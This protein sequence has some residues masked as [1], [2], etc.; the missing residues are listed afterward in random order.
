MAKLDSTD[1]RI[2]QLLSSNARASIRTIAELTH[3][4]RA[5]AY[6]RIQR[7]QERG[8]IRR[9]TVDIDPVARGLLTAAYVTMNVR[10][11]DWKATRD[12]L[13]KIPGVVHFALV[14]GE[15]DVILLVRAR[16]NADLRHIVL[17]QL[18][19]IPGVRNTR[20]LLIFDEPATEPAASEARI[21]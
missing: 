4:S 7:L 13:L 2:L 16:D 15:V 5:N 21:E 9:F 10:Q 20:T 6:A 3:V 17:E 1:E 8:V 14:G 11:T 12:E 18:Q 19:V